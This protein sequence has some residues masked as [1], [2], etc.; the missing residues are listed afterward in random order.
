MQ[1]LIEEN[2]EAH[3]KGL[4]K[5]QRNP[6]LFDIGRRRL[7]TRNDE[8]GISRR[9]IQEGKHQ[10]RH[11]NKDRNRRHYSATYK[12]QHRETY[13]FLTFHMNGADPSNMP[14][15]FFLYAVGTKNVP[16]GT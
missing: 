15:M 8:R 2:C 1:Y 6:Y 13:P 14:V 16:S 4:I 7:I 12:R 5:S 11:D 10:Q 9:E 3:V